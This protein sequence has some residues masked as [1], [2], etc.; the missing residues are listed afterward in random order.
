[1]QKAVLYGVL[2]VLVR[3]HDRARHG[4]GSPLVGAYQC[5]KRLGIAALRTRDQTLFVGRL[6]RAERRR[7][8]CRRGRFGARAAGPLRG[9]CLGADEREG[10]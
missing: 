10:G 9:V 6:E 7:R 1:V 4:V 2:R 8:G 5:A 3:R